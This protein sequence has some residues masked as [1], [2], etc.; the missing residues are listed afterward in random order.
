MLVALMLGAIGL[1]G[2]ALWWWR[3]A[4]GE[5]E[6]RRRAALL[7]GS[8]CLRPDHEHWSRTTG[9]GQIVLFVGGSYAARRLPA[10]LRA[11]LGTGTEGH[12]G[13]ILL[14]ELDGDVRQQCLAAIPAVFRERVIEVDSSLLP[15]GLLGDTIGD[16]LAA[17]HLWEN[18]LAAATR[19]WFSRID[20]EA[21]PALLLSLLSPG[22]HAALSLPVLHSFS[23]RFPRV[24]IYLTTILDNKR[25][26][27][28]RLPDLFAYLRRS[29]TIRGT[30]LLDNMRDS[31]RGDAGISALFG[32]MAAAS[33]SAARPTELWNAL[34]YLFPREQ[35]GSL[36]TLGV[37][38]E[39]LPV[40]YLAPRYGHPERYYTRADLV[41]EKICRAVQSLVEE[42]ALQSA[43]LPAAGPERLRIV[44][45]LVPLRPEPDLRELAVRVDQ[46]L[47]PWRASRE[48]DLLIYL[49]ST[50][51][52][53]TP[54]AREVPLIAILLQPLADDEAAL[55]ALARDCVFDPRFVSADPTR[56][57]A[58]HR[59]AGNG[60]QKE[61]A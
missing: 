43:P 20:R 30:L 36:A 59:L 11:C 15:A 46:A 38:A 54:E 51:A 41:E 49:A 21:R 24:P 27:R 35:P 61:A 8:V 48:G 23:R 55:Q 19:T 28:Q 47:A 56:S 17:R 16:V 4:L 39:S 14:V 33:W 10:I 3:Q 58:K 5:A 22:G 44:Y 45:I 26:V 29:G 7:R 31:L 9:Q 32:G 50:G 2:A 37:V 53:L 25:V 6:R 52:P 18:G 12:I 42:P 34:A 13:P 1:C 40:H 60:D 57:M